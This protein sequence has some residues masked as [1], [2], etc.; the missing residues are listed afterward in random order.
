MKQA[1]QQPKHGVKLPRTQKQLKQML[2]TKYL[3]GMAEAEQQLRN[4]L[5]NTYG[6]YIS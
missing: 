3:Q 5:Y 2:E 1:K 4:E 6:K